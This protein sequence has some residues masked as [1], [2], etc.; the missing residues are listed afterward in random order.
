MLD[1]NNMTITDA[2]EGLKAGAFSVQDLLDASLHRIEES[3]DLNS[4][5]SITKEY[6]T[7]RAALLDAKIS[8]GDDIPILA[9]IP[10]ALKDLFNMKGSF[11]TSGSLMLANYKSPYDAS[12]V[13]K[14]K[15]VDALIVGK[16]NMD[17][18]ACGVSNE[19]SYFGP[20]LNPWDK[21]RV[22]G[23]SSGGSAAAV[24]AGQ[25]F[26]ALGTDTGGSIRQPAS[27]CGVVGFKPSYGR[28]SRFGVNAMASSWDHVG[29]ITRTVK[30]AALVMN[31]IAGKDP[32]DATMPD[33][34]V[35]DYTAEL[36]DG[37]SGMTIGV[38]K[39]FFE[40]GVDE[41][42][43]DIV[44]SALKECEALG[45]TLKEVSLPMMKYGVAIYYVTTP[46]ELSTNLA[47]LDGVRFGYKPEGEFKNIHEYYAASRGDSFGD[48]I[49][50]R[51]M[52]GTF[53]LSAGYADA[54][55]KQAQRVRTLVI[56]D[57]ARVFKEVDVLMAPSSPTVAFKIGEKLDDPLAMYMCDVLTIPANAAGIPAISI[58]CGFNSEG[59]PVGLQIMGPQFEESLVLKVA[60]TY[61]Q[62]TKWHKLHPEI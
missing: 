59:L 49:K 24:A 35:L 13:T 19:T 11:T 57:F 29:P 3:K 34:P 37:I 27:L 46:G 62:A 40:E 26:Y 30:D 36:D 33:R 53:V 56:E 15:E 25:V 48:E 55:Y 42:V 20:V 31:V 60:Y 8:N 52:I 50:R 1:F 23:G 16:N 28:V 10:L 6:A 39:E 5:I 45:A 44:R 41:E 9:G 22:P 51:T 18:F 58:P 12:V 47:R 7:E 38:P 4:F 2:H 43:Q 17:E 61:E 14:L 32:Y 54:Y 21:T